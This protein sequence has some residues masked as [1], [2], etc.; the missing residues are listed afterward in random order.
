[1]VRGIFSEVAWAG[2]PPCARAIIAQ[3]NKKAGNSLTVTRTWDIG[4]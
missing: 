1:M 3:V 2:E 4:A